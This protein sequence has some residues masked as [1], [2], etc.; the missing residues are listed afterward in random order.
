LSQSPYVTLLYPPKYKRIV[1]F[2]SFSA[3][4]IALVELLM[5]TD[6]R[7]RTLEPK[8]TKVVTVILVFASVSVI[9]RTLLEFVNAETVRNVALPI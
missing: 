5:K 6:G 4:T 9:L 1:P 3:L 7:H 8:I 2:E